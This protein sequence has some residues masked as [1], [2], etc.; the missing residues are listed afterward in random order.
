MTEQVNNKKPQTVNSIYYI[1]W[2]TFIVCLYICQK[3]EHSCYPQEAHRGGWSSDLT[4]DMCC[5]RRMCRVTKEGHWKTCG[6]WLEGGLSRLFCEHACTLDCDLLH[7][8]CRAILLFSD[9]LRYLSFYGI[10]NELWIG[11]LLHWSRLRGA[12]PCSFRS[13]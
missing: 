1:H 13:F 5:D 3:R 8:D 6:G 7:L 10:E 11:G 2:Y 4:D 9:G 12:V